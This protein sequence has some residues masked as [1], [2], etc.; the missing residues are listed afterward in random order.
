M[1]VRKN[2]NKE[3]DWDF[4]QDYSTIDEN[5]TSINGSRVFHQKFGYGIIL[6]FDG[7]KANVDFDKSDEKKIYI[8]Y[9]QFKF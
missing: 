4:N 5:E 7:E 1:I 2:Q 8:K 9:L 6:D 3:I